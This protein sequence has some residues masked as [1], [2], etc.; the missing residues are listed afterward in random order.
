M[1]HQ[2]QDGLSVRFNADFLRLALRWLFWG[3]QWN[4][5]RFRKDCSWS[6]T[7]LATAACMWAWSDESTLDSR[8]QTARKITACIDA[9][10]W[11][12]AGSYQAFLKLLCRWTPALIALIQATFRRRMQQAF[13]KCWHM[14]GRV[15]FGVDGSRIELPRTASNQAVYAPSRWK[16]KAGRKRTNRR[17]KHRNTA[18]AKK[19]GVPQIWLTTMW[20]AG[21][22]LPWDYRIGPVDSSE[23]EHWM[24]MLPSLTTW[25][26]RSRWAEILKRAHFG[27]ESLPDVS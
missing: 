14:D 9:P 11:K 3:A 6:P 15:L 19:A 21:T 13:S 24:E 16:E 20:H 12:F 23:R 26:R 27:E 1:S 22:G 10:Q 25:S 17:K 5:I 2:D 18:H 7:Q 8:F 4:E